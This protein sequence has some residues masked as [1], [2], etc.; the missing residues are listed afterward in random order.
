[1]TAADE[2]T[3]WTL[4]SRSDTLQCVVELLPVGLQGRLLWNGRLHVSRV[5]ITEAELQAWAQEERD[6]HEAKGWVPVNASG[7]A[8][9]SH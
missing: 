6:E 7:S 8:E 1:M 4:Y 9:V 2:T 3:L 5:F